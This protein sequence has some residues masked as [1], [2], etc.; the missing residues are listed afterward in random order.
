[1]LWYKNQLTEE[2]VNQQMSQQ[3]Q[4]NDSDGNPI[5]FNIQIPEELE[6]EDNESED[7]E[8]K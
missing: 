2:N 7:S 5:Q 6:K 3:P 8:E 4:I 1:M